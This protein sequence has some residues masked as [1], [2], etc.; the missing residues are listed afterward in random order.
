MSNCFK[1]P[2]SFFCSDN[3]IKVS[4]PPWF[5]AGLQQDCSEFL[6]YFRWYFRVCSP[7][8]VSFDCRYLLNSLQSTETENPQPIENSSVSLDAGTLNIFRAI[9]DYLF[10]L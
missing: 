7:F 1:N 6:R 5:E 10:L 9:F 2:R 8:P 4:K 3:F